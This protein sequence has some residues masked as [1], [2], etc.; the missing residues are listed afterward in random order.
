MARR[1]ATNNRL[2]V[3]EKNNRTST[4]P[5]VTNAHRSTDVQGPQDC[6]L[7][8]LDAN[9]DREHGDYHKTMA[10][11]E[12]L[13]NSI[14]VFNDSDRCIRS[15]ENSPNKKI[16]LVTSGSL[17]KQ[18]VPRLHEQPQVKSIFI[19]CGNKNS[20][21]EW[22]RK[23]AKVKGVHTDIKGIRQGLEQIINPNMDSS[24]ASDNNHLT[25]DNNLLF[26]YTTILKEI[27]L[28]NTF[29]KND[30]QD[31]TH[32]LRANY[33]DDQKRLRYIEK[34]QHNYDNQAAVHWYTTPD[35]LR[36]MVDRA[37]ETMDINSLIR[38]GF[39]L[40]DLHQ[41]I[42][43]HRDYSDTTLTVYRPGRISRPK[44]ERFKERK[45]DLILF[46]RFLLTNKNRQICLESLRSTQRQSDSINVLYIMNVNTSQS[47]VPCASLEKFSTSSNNNEVLFSMHTV[48]HVDRI[49]QSKAQSDLF[50]VHLT[51]VNAPH[52]DLRIQI[53][54]LREEVNQI[55][56][57]WPQV[58]YLMTKLDDFDQADEAYRF[59]FSR[60]PDEV[61]QVS[62]HHRLGL[63]AVN[64]KNYE[65]AL[66]HYGKAIK[67]WERKSPSIHLRS[68]TL[69]KEKGSVYNKMNQP[70]EASTCYELAL[71]I[72]LEL[73]PPNHP[74]LISTYDSLGSVYNKL[75]Y[76]SQALSNYE[77]ALEI[78]ERTLPPDH[79][80]LAVSCDNIGSVCRNM[81]DFSQAVSFHQ[82]AVKIT[83]RMSPVNHSTL[84][85]YEKNLDAAKKHSSD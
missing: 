52:D 59:V 74:D 19:F 5:N 43:Q 60:I 70:S 20:H 46:S 40:R 68:A 80:D 10:Q 81:K 7:I 45:D 44:F 63:N 58:A 42:E 64:K 28:S 38:M 84:E 73:L 2:D 66:S 51:L 49:E 62:I 32:Y 54:D 39:F 36:S 79:P 77:K 6:L 25:L 75:G 56:R 8:W 23:F 30:I 11:F 33:A 34:F 31:F 18:V 76:Y 37:L 17:G 47:S 85:K 24:K 21:E 55:S 29:E 78:R 9:I 82:R 22:A 67:I 72:Y 15:I 13:T 3:G 48:F 83:Q 35:F 65:E 1:T 26:M 41:A 12:Q 61:E 71:E 4:S 16:H 69:Y 50:E 14:E 53:D 27:L 57:G